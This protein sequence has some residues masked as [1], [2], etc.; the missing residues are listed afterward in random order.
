MFIILNI[1][2]TVVNGAMAYLNYCNGNFACFGMNMFA[3]GFT[4]AAAAFIAITK[5]MN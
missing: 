5:I 2:L 1:A 4:V 3:C